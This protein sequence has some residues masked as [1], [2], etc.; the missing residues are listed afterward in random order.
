MRGDE[1]I[2]RLSAIRARH[3]EVIAL[4]S[5][6]KITMK[7]VWAVLRDIERDVTMVHAVYYTQEVC[8]KRIAKWIVHRQ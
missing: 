3:L 2:L 6:E 8:I 1:G 7:D 5:G 4:F